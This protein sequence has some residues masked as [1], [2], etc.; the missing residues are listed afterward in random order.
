M[1]LTPKEDALVSQIRKRCEYWR[2]WKPG[3]A[4]AMPLILV[5]W[6]VIFHRIARLDIEFVLLLMFPV[7]L[8]NCAVCGFWI[9]KLWRDWRG[10]ATDVL[11]LRLINEIS[12]RESEHHAGG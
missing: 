10:N 8:L 1:K 6:F 7:F 11:L 3:I 12:E 9:G 2:K 5:A 4:I